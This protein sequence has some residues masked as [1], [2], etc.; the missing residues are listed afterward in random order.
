MTQQL[1]SAEKKAM[2]DSEFIDYKSYF[3][4]FLGAAFLILVV[5]LF[6]PERKSERAMRTTERQPAGPS[7]AISPIS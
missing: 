1:D 2:T 5:E 7:K 6:W 4:W 3:Q